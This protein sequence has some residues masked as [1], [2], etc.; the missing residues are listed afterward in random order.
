MGLSNGP[1]GIYTDHL[2]ASLATREVNE[3]V[4]AAGGSTS[5]AGCGA[6][7][8]NADTTNAT[9]SPNN[10]VMISPEMEAMTGDIM[11][12]K[13]F[14]MVSIWASLTPASA[15]FWRIVFII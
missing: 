4:Y 6:R 11:N 9:T 2:M 3:C 12:L 8:R 5:K 15:H 14:S 7:L 10:T 1:A 13:P